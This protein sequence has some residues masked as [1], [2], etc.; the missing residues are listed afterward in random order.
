MVIPLEKDQVDRSAIKEK[1]LQND[2]DHLIIPF[3]ASHMSALMKNLG[4]L[5]P[6]LKIYGT[7]HFSFGVE[8]RKEEWKLYEGAYLIGPLFYDQ[9]SGS[10]GDSQAAFLYDAVNLVINA[11]RKVGTEREAITA[12]ISGSTYTDG[13][14][15]SISF[16]DLGNRKDAARLYQIS[17]GVPQLIQ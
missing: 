8:R 12:Y 13:A 16:D 17:G 9:S 6:E 5:K 15:G 4:E 11:I 2:P 10:P 1:I 14:T 7:I 3:D